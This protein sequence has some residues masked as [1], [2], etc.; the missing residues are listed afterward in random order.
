MSHET[1]LARVIKR[2]TEQGFRVRQTERNHWQFYAPNKEDIVTT[3]GTPSDFRG[4]HNFLA[5]MKRAGYEDSDGP[6]TTMA[7][8]LKQAGAVPAPVDGDGETPPAPADTRVVPLAAREFGQHGHNPAVGRS[9]LGII[10]IVRDTLFRHPERTYTVEELNIIVRS[11]GLTPG[12]T[13]VSGALMR[14][15]DRGQA[16]RVG[17]GNYRC[18]EEG[19]A[20]SPVH[21]PVPAPASA[22]VGPD[23]T[24][25]GTTTGDDDVDAD[26]RALDDALVALARLETVIRRNR[27]IAARTADLK[28][29]LAG[30]E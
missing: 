27:A 25:P 6:E 19:R 1:D 15:C 13:S 23:H 18:E 20:T 26:L 2:A 28:K 9:H 21:V 5:A 29:L 4:W 12:D 3:G 30:M 16:R 7:A 11:Q 10:D 14:L 22:Y 8:A 24:V 17:R